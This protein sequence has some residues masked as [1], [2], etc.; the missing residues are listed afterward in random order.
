[1]GQLRELKRA[2]KTQV[3]YSTGAFL[4][5]IHFVTKIATKSTTTATGSYRKRDEMNAKLVCY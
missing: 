4:V 3:L 5:S 1:M 2:A